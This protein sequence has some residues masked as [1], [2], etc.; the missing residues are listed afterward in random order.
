MYKME[1][2]VVNSRPF[3]EIKDIGD[4]KDVWTLSVRIVDIW[5]LSTNESKNILKWSLWM[6]MYTI[7]FTFDFN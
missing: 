1:D 3:D 2:R 6:H 7:Y 5:L 4:S